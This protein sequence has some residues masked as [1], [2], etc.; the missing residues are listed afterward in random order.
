MIK[1][2]TTKLT[3]E[4]I[5]S[6]IPKEIIYAEVA[7]GGAMGNSGGIMIYLIKEDTLIC[8]ETNVF[9]DEETYS[10]AEELLL[11]HQS[12]FKFEVLETQD[13]FFDY[14]YGGMGNNVFVNKSAALEI[15]DG[16]FIYRNRSL[17]YQILPS[18]IGV[19][20]GVVYAM[21]KPKSD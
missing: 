19:F 8:Y 14:F 3:K 20:N 11:K 16:F 21:K 6:I 17:V 4:V 10:Q 18:V 12:Q 9:T 13:N 15:N 2:T 7:G 5:D 1:P